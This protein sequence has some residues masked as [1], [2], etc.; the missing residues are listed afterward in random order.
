MIKKK[1]EKKQRT[2]FELG[3]RKR[4]EKANEQW[5]KGRKEER[6]RSSCP[7]T[8]CYFEVPQHCRSA[9]VT[10]VVLTEVVHHGNGW[11]VTL[12]TPPHPSSLPNLPHC[13]YANFTGRTIEMSCLSNTHAHAPD[14]PD[15][16]GAMKECR[17]SQNGRDKTSSP[18]GEKGSSLALYHCGISDS[19]KKWG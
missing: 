10:L 3:K 8:V 1:G 2:C 11:S 19:R 12:R 13:L 16:S 17:T 6:E 9:V 4:K 18:R 14:Q 7:Y 5:G 15:W